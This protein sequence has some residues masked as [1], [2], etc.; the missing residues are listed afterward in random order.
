MSTKPRILKGL[1]FILTPE[2][3]EAVRPAL[4]NAE[5][6]YANTGKKGCVVAQIQRL[7]N[8]LGD[9]SDPWVSGAFLEE[10]FSSRM[11]RALKLMLKVKPRRRP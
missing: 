2:Q 3:Y 4:E 5:S 7:T 1:T 9:K 10:S 6:Y 11:V 8:G